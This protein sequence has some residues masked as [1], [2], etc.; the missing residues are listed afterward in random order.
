MVQGPV[1]QNQQPLRWEPGTH[2]ALHPGQSAN[3]FLADQLLGYV[4]VLHPR[5][6]KALDLRQAPILVQLD[7]NVLRPASI[8]VY[9][10]LSKF[11]GVRRDLA[12]LVDEK[13]S[14]RMILDKIHEIGRIEGNLLNNLHIFDVYQ[15][16]GIEKGKK[17]IALGLTFQ[18]PS[19]TLIDAYIQT[20]IQ[21]IIK[22][23]EDE[24]KATLRT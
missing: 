9:Q 12:L 6:L 16:K 22:V 2:A 15:G 5:L 17:S 18:D 4:G 19:R 20:A 11:P 7:L 3:L 21:S 23:L 8:P 24:F 13:L 1:G 14:I 10:P